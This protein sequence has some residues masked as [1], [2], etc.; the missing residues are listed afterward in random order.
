MIVKFDFEKPPTWRD[1]AS[2]VDDWDRWDREC[3]RKLGW[4]AGLRFWGVTNMPKTRTLLCRHWPHRLCWSWL[5][6]VG[7][8]RPE[9][10]GP[11]RFIFVVNRRYRH[12]DIRLWCVKLHA[13]WQDSSWMVAVGPTYKPDAP[14][15]YWKRDLANAEPAGSA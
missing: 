9:F 12:V 11:R 14:T 6:W 8:V 2:N 1:R 13:A 7:I 5:I 15:I 4:C 3:R 10:D